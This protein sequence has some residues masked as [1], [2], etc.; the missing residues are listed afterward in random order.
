[1]LAPGVSARP[2]TPRASLSRPADETESCQTAARHKSIKV[3]KTGKKVT[4][5]VELDQFKYEL[6]TL[7]KPLVEVRDSL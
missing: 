6:S 4:L 5:V 2:G 3:R 7:D 1:M